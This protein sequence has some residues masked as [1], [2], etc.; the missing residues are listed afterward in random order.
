[1]SDKIIDI[2]SSNLIGGVGMAVI[3][4]LITKYVEQVNTRIKESQVITLERIVDL[5]KRI[6]SIEEKYRDVLDIILDK[7]SK[8]E[9]RILGIISKM[10]EVSPSELQAEVDKFREESVNELADMRLRVERVASVVQKIALEPI[11][12]SSK[13]L[14]LAKLETVKEETDHRLKY[15][16]EHFDKFTRL[17]NSINVKQKEHDFKIANLVMIKA[18]SKKD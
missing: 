4:W 10:G 9:D 18:V 14:V 2:I 13:K 12:E 1:M 17:L 5:A 8:W 3:G 16:E 6:G 15:L 11:D 7:F